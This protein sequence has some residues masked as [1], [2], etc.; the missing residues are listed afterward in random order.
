MAIKVGINGF[1]RIGRLTFRAI[2]DK[3]PG[4]IEVVGINDLADPKTNS[5]LFKWDS[6]YG[7]YKG[8]AKFDEDEIMVDGK[9]VR[10]FKEK[11]PAAIDWANVGAQIVVEATGIFTD[12][13]RAAKHLGDTVKKV[14]ISAPAKGE[15]F[16]VVLGVNEDKY[17]PATHHVVSNASCTTNCIA[18]MTKVLVDKFGIES[19]LMTTIHSYTNDQKVQD[20]FHEDLRRARSAGQNMIPTSTGAAKALGLVI[21]E[22]QGKLNGFAIRVP[23]PTVSIVDL[24]AT[25]AKAAS[26]EEINTAMREA[27]TGPMIGILN[28][29]DE[30]LVSSDYIG[31]TFSCTV[32]SA[33]TMQIGDR[34][35]KVVGWYDNEYAYAMRCADLIR[36]MESKGL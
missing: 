27:A 2:Q 10:S 18:P 7:P 20:Q 6:T 21:P 11:D 31:N 23:T 5:H 19:G 12:R 3:Y 34:M 8:E 35:A 30:P 33:L 28:V 16:T 15:D 22:V 4:E 14:I 36:F 9:R 17:D 26:A 25:L 1:G 13:D 29:S 24:V 32:D